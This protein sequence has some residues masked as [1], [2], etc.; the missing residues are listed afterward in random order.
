M[1]I[2]IN[3]KIKTPNLPNY[4]RTE[5]SGTIDIGSLDEEAYGEFEE[6]FVDALRVHW[7]RRKKQVEKQNKSK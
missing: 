1:D 5:N 6:Q 2:T 7:I 4:L 3:L